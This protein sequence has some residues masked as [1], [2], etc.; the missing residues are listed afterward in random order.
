MGKAKTRGKGEG[1]IYFAHADDCSRAID[2]R[3]DGDCAGDWVAQI[4][5]GRTASG[6]RRYSRRYRRN[7]SGAQTALAELQRLHGRGLDPELARQPL[8]RYLDAW[9]DGL[10][11]V[12]APNT[13]AAYRG[14]LAHIKKHLAGVRLDKLTPVQIRRALSAI[15]DSGL[16]SKS[17]LNIRTTLHT[18]IEQA[19]KDQIL[20][21]NPVSVVDRPKVDRDDV[22]PLTVVQARAVLDQLAGDRLYPLIAVAV[23]VGLRLGEA[24]GLTWGSVDLE[25]GVIAV[26]TQTQLLYYCYDC[27][28]HHGEESGCPT[29]GAVPTK[30]DKHYRLRDL[31]SKKSR[32]DIPLPAF[33]IRALT[34]HRKAQAAERLANGDRWADGCC[35]ACGGTDW[36]LVFT[37][38]SH[39]SAGRPL[40]ETQARKHFQDACEAAGMRR[41]R[42]H[43][44]RHTAATL[45]LAQGVPLWQV[46]EIL[47]HSSIQVTKD[48]YGHL[49][50]EH[51]RGAADQMEGVLGG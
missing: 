28:R 11:G 15:G 46:Q 4:E 13:I 44:L 40:H 45:L 31:K 6:R 9:L 23:A 34:E 48:M 10:R 22:K 12:R 50:V 41:F 39:R 43:D 37:T 35:G 38:C 51:L 47:G 8:E 16:K 21:W 29:C 42:P 7:R 49:E 1:S 2:D 27:R 14:D 3:E 5:A 25:R 30:R 26:R 24:L 33:A 20:D 19:K 17:V 32:R 18:A 36:G